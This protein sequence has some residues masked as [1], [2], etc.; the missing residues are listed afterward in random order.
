MKDNYTSEEWEKETEKN[1]DTHNKYWDEA[2]RD[3]TAIRSSLSSI[4]KE[5]YEHSFGVNVRDITV[6]EDTIEILRQDWGTDVYAKKEYTELPIKYKITE[7]Q[8]TEL[9]P[10]VTKD[11]KNIEISVT[12]PGEKIV[13]KTNGT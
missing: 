2:A 9:S 3:M 7:E 1:A 11:C 4:P 13:L 10:W 8:L 5:K 6:K 12:K